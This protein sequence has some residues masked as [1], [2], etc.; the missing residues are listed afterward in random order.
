MCGDNEK[1][2]V[3]AFEGWVEELRFDSKA[4]GISVESHMQVLCIR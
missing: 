1:E 2:L 4:D 3:A